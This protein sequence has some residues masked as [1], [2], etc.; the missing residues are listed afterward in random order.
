[1]CMLVIGCVPRSDEDAEGQISDE[2]APDVGV[3]MAKATITAQKPQLD[4]PASTP[5][6][7]VLVP[8]EPTAVP[9]QA[10]NTPSSQS[11]G[12]QDEKTALEFI[13]INSR[14]NTIAFEI[15]GLIRN[16]GEIDVMD[17]DITVQLYNEA[18]EVVDT[19]YGVTYPLT[20]PVGEVSL[21][22]ITFPVVTLPKVEELDLSIEWTEVEPDY[23]W[24][25]NGFEIVSAE[26]RFEPDLYK[27]TGEVLNAGASSAPNIT[28]IGLF[29][30]ENGGLIDHSMTIVE[31]V[32]AGTSASFSMDVSLIDLGNM[33]EE[34][35]GFE[36]LVEGY[37]E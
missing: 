32:A 28:I 9:P 5:T 24:T 16:N 1:M 14:G 31:D 26:A 22:Y 29:Y 2:A 34:V 4:L 3:P 37:R 7:V 27:V 8:A 21:F 25:R 23:P 33:G 12:P 13:D 18:G 15:F 19:R 6:E 35:A 10:T 36:L 17:I 20:I 30:N 11:P